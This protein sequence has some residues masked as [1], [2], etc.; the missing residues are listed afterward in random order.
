MKS[1]QEVIE[2]YTDPRKRNMDRNRGI[3]CE[4]IVKALAQAGKN[5][6]KK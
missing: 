3:Q 6:T 5:D 2:A 1:R 4:H